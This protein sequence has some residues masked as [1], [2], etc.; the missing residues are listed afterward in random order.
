M[1]EITDPSEITVT[2][3][4]GNTFEFRIP[5]VMDQGKIGIKAKN[6][7]KLTF[8]DSDGSEEGLDPETM[9]LFRALALFSVALVKSDAEWIWTTD[10]NGKPY[11]DP[12]TV[13]SKYFNTIMEVYLGY[14]EAQD[15]FRS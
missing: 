14:L 1:A 13:P 9:H 7:R 2:S 11:F 12:M 8:P 3:K 10:K 4:E 15:S 5:T 6:L